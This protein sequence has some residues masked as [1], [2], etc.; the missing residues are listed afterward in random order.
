MGD[1]LSQVVSDSHELGRHDGNGPF[2]L[3]K[4]Q[5]SLKTIEDVART[6]PSSQMIP[7]PA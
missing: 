3:A 2:D 4:V 7:N 5:A 6:S 1:P